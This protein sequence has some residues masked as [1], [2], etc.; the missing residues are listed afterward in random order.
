MMKLK[1]GLARHITQIM[2]MPLFGTGSK[3]TGLQEAIATLETLDLE[4]PRGDFQRVEVIIDYNNGDSI[5]AT[6]QNKF[7]L[8]DFLQTLG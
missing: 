5:R 7:L 3:V 4:N 1:N 6:F 2:I 8:A